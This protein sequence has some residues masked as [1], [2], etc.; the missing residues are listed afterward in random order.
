MGR[1]AFCFWGANVPPA[2]RA[3]MTPAIF[4]GRLWLPSAC[5]LFEPV[6]TCNVLP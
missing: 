1:G 2:D 3:G 5:F 4:S 6:Y